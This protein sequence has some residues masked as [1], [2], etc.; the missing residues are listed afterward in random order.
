LQYY[1]PATAFDRS[2]IT[3]Y[4]KIYTDIYESE[5]EGGISVA[6]EI[7][8]LIREKEAKG[9]NCVLALPGGYSPKSV[10]TELIRLHKQEGLSFKRVV[11]FLISEFYPLAET[12]PHSNLKMVKEYLLD[13]IDIDPRNI[14]SQDG[15]IEKSDVGEHAQRYEQ[16]IEQQGGLDYALLAIGR[17]GNVGH[18]EPGSQINSKTRLMLLD[19]ESLKD[20]SRFY[21]SVDNM[22]RY[23]IT[24][25]IFTLMQARKVVIVAFGESKSKVVRQLVEE[26]Y[27]DTIPASYFQQHTN[28]KVIIDLVAAEELTRIKTPWL[29]TTCQWNDLMVRRAIVWLC[30][31]TNKPILKLTNKDYN[32]HGLHELLALYGSAYNVNIKVFN[33]LQH[34]ITGWPGGKPNEDDKYRPERAT[35]Y[36]K[37]VLVFSPHPDDD[38]ISMGGTFR[39]L[40]D[41]NHDVHVAY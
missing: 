38:V 12:L 10:Y 36:P 28:A 33:D 39:R 4:E 31:L 14:F 20:T 32:E 6:R 7:A 3:R 1:K 15:T 40:V 35:P 9:Q 22:P 23:A 2:V 29:V 26:K 18:N 16:L 41:Q 17:L 30:Q 37:R 34:T 11:V 8:S 21:Q 25:G 5:S 13:H 24:M 27:S 19:P